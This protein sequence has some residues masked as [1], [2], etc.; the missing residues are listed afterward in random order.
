MMKVCIVGQGLKGYEFNHTTN[1]R[2]NQIMSKKWYPTMDERKQMNL[3]RR[4]R[5]LANEMKSLVGI[6]RYFQE[7]LPEKMAANGR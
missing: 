6:I 4:N 1:K 7:R 2:R 3:A 5:R